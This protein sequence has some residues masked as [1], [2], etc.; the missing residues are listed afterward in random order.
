MIPDNIISSNGGINNGNDDDLHFQGA[1]ECVK[2]ERGTV[3]ND[4]KECVFRQ[5]QCDELC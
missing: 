5:M 3:N 2:Y 4:R 1:F